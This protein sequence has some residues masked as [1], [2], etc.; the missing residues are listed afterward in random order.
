MKIKMIHSKSINAA[1]TCILV[2]EKLIV[3]QVRVDYCNKSA[4]RKI[5]ERKRK[6]R[7][8]FFY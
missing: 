5:R 3:I 8:R 7:E 4:K 1:V 6:L 2:K